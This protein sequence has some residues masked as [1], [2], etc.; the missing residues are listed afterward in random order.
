MTTIACN[1]KEIAADRLCFTHSDEEYRARKIHRIGESFFAESGEQCESI[2]DWLRRGARWDTRPEFDKGVDPE[3]VELHPTGIY[4]Y[5][6]ELV[7][8]K[9]EQEFY[10]S[11]SGRLV[12]L[13]CMQ[14][15]NLTPAQA[16][17]EAAKVDS[18]TGGPVDV[19]RV[20]EAV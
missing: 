8:E 11:G 16:V 15:L 20:I 1:A 12:A 5:G 13:Y 19:E 2:I 3:V 18:W 14:V 10:A 7:R 4:R 17:A 9:L 6:R